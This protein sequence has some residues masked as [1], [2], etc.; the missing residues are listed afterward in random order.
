[1]S[2]IQEFVDLYA[3]VFKI[4]LKFIPCVA[5]KHFGL[6]FATTI[7]I[8]QANPKLNSSVL[9]V[10]AFTVST[11]DS[12]PSFGAWL[13]ENYAEFNKFLIGTVTQIKDPDLIKNF[14]SVQSK[15]LIYNELIF[16][17][18]PEYENVMRLL[19]ESL[20]E[21][22]EYSM[23]KEILLFFNSFVGVPKGLDHPKMLAV[24]PDL[25]K[26]LIYLLPEINR[27]F[28]L[29]EGFIFQAL[30]KNYG[31]GNNELKNFIRASFNEARFTGVT[32]KQKV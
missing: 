1:M 21:I 27:N 25:I 9:A 17:D 14:A 29:Y 30:V 26:T 22:N 5:G 16:L 2:Q 8:F 23:T 12:D 6:I 20:L 18:S 13:K 15:I 32:E 10:F 31:K 28:L 11:L 19:L 4:L 7:K 24:L 3:R